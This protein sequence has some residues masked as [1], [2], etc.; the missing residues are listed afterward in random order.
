MPRAASV[1]VPVELRSAFFDAIW[2]LAYAGSF[3]KTSRPGSDLLFERFGSHSMHAR[4]NGLFILWLVAGAFRF[5]EVARLRMADV[6]WAGG[7]V[8]V[9]RSKRGLNPTRSI[10]RNLIEATLAWRRRFNITSELVFPNRFG[11]ELNVNVFNRDVMGPLGELFG[12]R[13]STHSMR[14]TS[15]QELLRIA[16]AQGLGIKAVQA[17]LGHRNL[18]STETYLRKQATREIRLDLSR[19]GAES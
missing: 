9:R 8:A 11:R 2:E 13:L 1:P 15:S 4:R 17:S 6:D 10:D 14:D 7:T 5:N 3:F 12:C 16:E 19:M 18:N